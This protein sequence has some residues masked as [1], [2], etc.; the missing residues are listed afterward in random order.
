MYKRHDHECFVEIVDKNHGRRVIWKMKREE[1]KTIS[2]KKNDKRLKLS[3]YH[4]KGGLYYER[5]N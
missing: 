5:C 3:L 2:D 4:E 1:E